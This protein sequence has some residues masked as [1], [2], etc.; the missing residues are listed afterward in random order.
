MGSCLEGT[1]T[2]RLR[3]RAGMKTPSTW[4]KAV[5]PCCCPLMKKVRVCLFRSRSTPTVA[6]LH[7]PPSVLG[8]EAPGSPITNHTQL[9]MEGTA[10]SH[11]KGARNIVPDTQPPW[12]CRELFSRAMRLF[13]KRPH[14]LRATREG[15]TPHV[16]FLTLGE[17][18]YSVPFILTVP[19]TWT[20]REFSGFDEQVP[21]ENLDWGA[22]AGKAPLSAVERNELGALD[23]FNP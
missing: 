14:Q 21:L 2:L 20:P 15:L 9:G 5:G 7:T 17:P 4:L 19:E 18:A 13:P 16:C 11:F 22:W 23:C 10:P 3:L 8:R 12:P 1:C 6:P